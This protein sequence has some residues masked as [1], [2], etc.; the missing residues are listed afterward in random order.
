MNFI[1]TFKLFYRYA[2]PY[3]AR[4]AL[5]LLA[6]FGVDLL[7]ALPPLVLKSFIDHAEQVL[8]GTLG[9]YAPFFWLGLAYA[10]IAI[11][12]GVCRY[13]WRVLLIKSSFLA[14][15]RLREDYFAKLQKLP[16][17]FYERNSIGD[18][19]ALATNDVEA[20]R[21]AMGPGVLVFA[22]A[23][24][25][26]ISLPPAMLWLSPK[27]TALALCPMVVLPFVIISAEKLV[28]ARFSK[29]QEQFSL[30]TG[31]A[32]ENV[33]GIRVIKAFN[34]EWTQLKRFSQLGRDFVR[35]N[36]RLAA[37]Q[38]IFEPVFLL[39]VTCGLALLIA[40]AGHDVLAGAVT[41]G[42]F[43]A[44]TRYLDN[45][46][47]PM[48]AFGMSV[49][50]YQ[51]GK[52]SLKRIH[53][54]LDEKEEPTVDGPVRFAPVPL[55]PLLEARQLSF[56]YPGQ[57]RPALRDV[58]FKIDEGSRVALVGP[59]GS[60]K[61]TLVRLLCGLYEVPPGTL[62]WKGVDV[63]EIPLE[64]RRELISV[65][66]QDVFLFSE[67]LH[68]N[69]ALGF[70]EVGNGKDRDAEILS[71]LDSAGLAA[72]ARAWGLESAIGEKGLNLSGGQKARVSLARALGRHAPL[73]ILDDALSS[74]DAET[75]SR[76][77]DRLTEYGQSKGTL[78]MATHRF[79][80]LWTMDRVLVLNHG[81]VAQYGPPEALTEAPGLYRRML[82]LQ[83]MEEALG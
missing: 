55:A 9:K 61:S 69:V 60:G 27:L 47:W 15:E 67:T 41:L 29:V 50:L 24:F 6:L 46:A 12:Q 74:V 31:F 71:A 57:P 43:V 81:T 83:R 1:E 66:P 45:L 8:H 52:T 20:V 51:R 16:P 34:R 10:S 76:I 33:E 26:F 19:M 53:E 25:L 75:E 21:F 5:G 40:F 77:L 78:L 44:F 82:E 37:A 2:R 59:V 70:N 63:T 35:L 62:F 17:S 14:A 30:L 73:L 54:V 79:A 32:Q 18:L 3:R 22:D 38:S 65:V 42:T 49:T 13:L 56:T 23:V 48:T 28:H 58:S 4:F 72:E 64:R 68:W 80:R 11:G 39:T 7:N 36:L